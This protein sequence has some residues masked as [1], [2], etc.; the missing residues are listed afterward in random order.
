M[1]ES[2]RGLLV[3]GIAAARTGNPQDKQE[4]RF[5]LDW[6]LRSPDADPDQQ[7]AAWLELSQIEDDPKKKRDCLENVIAIDQANGPARR[8]LA[9]LDGR[10]K[11]E[12]MIDPSQTVE[13]VKPVATPEPSAVRRYVCPKCGGKMSYDAAQHVLTCVDCG[14][15]VPEDQAVQPGALIADQDFFATLPTA[16]A[17]RS[18]CGRAAVSIRLRRDAQAHSCLDGPSTLSARRP[19]RARR[20]CR[21]ARR[22][23]AIL[24]FQP[25]R[26]LEVA[27]GGS[28]A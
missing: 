27:C 6:V 17:Y 15:H 14:N 1:S 7:V 4:A 20:D 24:G 18:A 5:Y 16:K 28:R 2:V 3:R 8:G 19:R 11:P 10:L 23:S 13:P 26:D 22:V 21:A 9:I 25:G 12:D